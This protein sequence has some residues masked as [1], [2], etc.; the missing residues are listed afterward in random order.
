MPFPII[1]Y[2]YAIGAA[3]ITT[4]LSATSTIT[5]DDRSIAVIIPIKKSNQ[6]VEV[7]IVAEDY[8]YADENSL[9]NGIDNI[10]LDTEKIKPYTE[11]KI[12]E[13]QQAPVEDAT[14]AETGEGEL[15]K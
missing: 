12:N 6:R 10:L 14:N 15:E 1:V 8:T 11:D 9:D 13:E 5:V 7:K 4:D 2:F 3:L